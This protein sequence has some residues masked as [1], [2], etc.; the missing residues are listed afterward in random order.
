MVAERGAELRL[1]EFVRSLQDANLIDAKFL[2]QFGANTCLISPRRARFKAKSWPN[3][4]ILVDDDG[5][6]AYL[7]S[8]VRALEEHPGFTQVT[9]VGA[10]AAALAW[11]GSSGAVA[12]LTQSQ[13]LDSV[14]SAP[15]GAT[16]STTAMSTSAKVGAVL[17]AAALEIGRAHV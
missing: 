17:A 14:P 9:I 5:P 2:S 1:K 11:T 7:T 16:A 13:F 10:A 3:A 12:S 6:S 15:Q 4:I 8:V